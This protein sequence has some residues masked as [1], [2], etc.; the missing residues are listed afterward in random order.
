L[1]PARLRSPLL[2]FVQ[3]DSK[4]RFDRAATERWFRRE[5]RSYVK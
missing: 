2:L 5:A 1:P 3:L 4:R